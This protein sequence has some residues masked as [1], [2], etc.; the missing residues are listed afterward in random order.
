[1]DTWSVGG[2][3]GTGSND[4][5]VD[6]VFVPAER[7]FTFGD[8]P[9][10]PGPLYAFPLFALLTPTIG[11]VALGIARGA[12][13]ALGDL[14]VHKIPTGFSEPL[15]YHSRIQAAVARA[16]AKL[17]SAR[18]FL[19]QTFDAAWRDVSEGR[20]LTLHQRV[21]LRLAA[22]HAS[23]SAA[24]AVDLMYAAG[25]SSAIYTKNPLER[26]FRDIHVVTHHV[27]VQPV[28][29]E[30]VGSALL[31]LDASVVPPL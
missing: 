6:D 30:A 5:V 14:A 4:F 10:Q 8:R 21:L 23:D 25:G 22:V 3:R 19:V 17:Q 9:V 31:G 7:T 24:E 11:A 18:A 26:A 15:R 1:V 27:M 2:L 13:D 20:P 16:E 12:I 29:Y 28:Q